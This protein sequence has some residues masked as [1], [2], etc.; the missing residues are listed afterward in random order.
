[1]LW[2]VFLKVC[3]VVSNGSKMNQKQLISSS[4]VVDL[5][6]LNSLFLIEFVHYSYLN[7]Y[8]IQ[9]EQLKLVRNQFEQTVYYDADCLTPE[10]ACLIANAADWM[11]ASDFLFETLLCIE[12]YSCKHGRRSSQT[13]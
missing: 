11:T 4:L 5:W 6:Y 10:E 1:M 12:T 8:L 13:L 9:S 2:I 7:C 3:V